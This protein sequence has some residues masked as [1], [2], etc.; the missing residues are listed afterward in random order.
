MEGL[1]TLQDSFSMSMYG[2]SALPLRSVLR[3]QVS[4]EAESGRFTDTHR[5][6]IHSGLYM[7]IQVFKDG[8]GPGTRVVLIATPPRELLGKK[9]SLTET[10]FSAYN[11]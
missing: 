5:H 2:I 11:A 7:Y 8:A 3:G 9:S 4:L 10:M 6:F 1:R